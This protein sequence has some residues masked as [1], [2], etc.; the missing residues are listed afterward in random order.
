MQN[1]SLILDVLQETWINIFNNISKYEERGYFYAW[2]NKI[3]VREVI[4][5]G[6]KKIYKVIHINSNHDNG[7]LQDAIVEKN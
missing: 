4:R 5:Q 1:E 7:Q 2:A 3:L 6:K